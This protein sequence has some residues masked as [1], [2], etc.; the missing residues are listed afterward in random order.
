MVTNSY[1]SLACGQTSLKDSNQVSLLHKENRFVWRFSQ[2]E[3]EKVLVVKGPSY[4]VS[5]ECE[6]RCPNIWAPVL[7]FVQWSQT[8]YIESAVQI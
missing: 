8:S 6:A 2:S 7:L 1:D 3:I 4:S 5:E